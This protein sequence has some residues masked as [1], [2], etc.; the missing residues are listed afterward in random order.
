MLRTRSHQVHAHAHPYSTAQQTPR[1][2][3]FDRTAPRALS[4]C[5]AAKLHHRFIDENH[6]HEATHKRHIPS[7]IFDRGRSCTHAR[8]FLHDVLQRYLRCTRIRPEYAKIARAPHQFYFAGQNRPTT[9]TPLDLTPSRLV[10]K[11]R[12]NPVGY[13]GT[14][15]AMLAPQPT[16]NLA[17]NALCLL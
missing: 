9:H 5:C 15:F 7:C 12:C 4:L 13:A 17:A 3:S 1:P 16:M 11:L 14:A 10:D 8:K 2:G 6:T